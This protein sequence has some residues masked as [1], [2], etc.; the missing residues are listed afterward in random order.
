MAAG[1]VEDSEKLHAQLQDFGD[2]DL[3][4]QGIH[5]HVPGLRFMD[6][7]MLTSSAAAGRLLGWWLMRQRW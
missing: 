3:V 5:D 6:T 2:S 4:L 1:A 7:Q